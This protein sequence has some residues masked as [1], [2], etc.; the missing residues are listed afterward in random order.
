MKLA[1]QWIAASIDMVPSIIA[2]ASGSFE[3]VK[4][5]EQ[6][7]GRPSRRQSWPITMLPI[8]GSGVPKVGAPDRSDIDDRKLPKITGAPGRSSC[9]SAQPAIV[10][11][12]ALRDGAG[13]GDRPHRAAQDEGHD[14]RR[15]IGA[16]IGAQGPRH[17]AVPDQRRVDVHIAQDHAVGVGEVAPNRRCGPSRSNPRP[18]PRR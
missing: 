18:G 7:S 15:L 13:V 16:G 10:S 12:S 2:W 6:R 11:A 5:P 4:L 1:P 17:R 9:V 14:H 3:V 8:A